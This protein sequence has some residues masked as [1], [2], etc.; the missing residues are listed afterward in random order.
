MIHL[1]SVSFVISFSFTPIIN[2][3]GRIYLPEENQHKESTPSLVKFSEQ[4]TRISIML[5]NRKIREDDNSQ[6]PK[7]QVC[8]Q[9][10]VDKAWSTI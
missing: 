9:E 2:E 5:S 10:S 3:L 4:S 8:F 6:N 7:N 1:Q